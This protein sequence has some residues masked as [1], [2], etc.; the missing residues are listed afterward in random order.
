MRGRANEDPITPDSVLRLAQAV[1]QEFRKHPGSHGVVIGKDTRLS[2]YMIESALTSGFIS[3]G[4]NVF[5]VGPLPTPAIAMLTRSL[6]ADLGVMISAS[7][8]PA[9]DN[10]LKFFGPD[11]CKLDDSVQERIEKAYASGKKFSLA[12]PLGMGRARRIDDAQG[13]YIEFV[14]NSFPKGLR[15]EGLKIVI[16][17]AHGAAYKVAPTVFWE[18]GAEVIPINNKPDGANINH[19]CGVLYP[20]Q[21]SNHVKMHQADIGIA[22]DGDADRVLM[23]DENGKRIDG[24]F[25]LAAIA[26][27]WHQKKILRGQGVIATVMSNLGL[28]HYLQTLG[29][30][31]VRT[32]V[33]D[34]YVSEHMR[35]HGY[36]VGGEQSGHI[37]LGDSATTG[38]GLMAALQILALLI[39]EQKPASYLSS[40]FLPF[41]QV[42]KNVSGV[43]KEFLQDPDVIAVVEE[44]QKDLGENG[45][46]IVR[47]SGTENVIRIMAEGE[48]QDI[49]DSFVHQ[50]SEMLENYKSRVFLKSV[51]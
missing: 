8:N 35:L 34:R 18:L 38:D 46:L 20:A 49:L 14:K 45:R 25:L 23:I 3:M 10:G 40:F 36:N 39:E 28:E 15:L 42:L 13:R 32:H 16:D 21:L 43:Q 19:E 37:I 22:L 33:G 17:C 41:P 30:H 5:L 7:H 2:G 24:D 4:M 50:V 51:G 26:T 11:G 6:R 12:S 47:A 44:I 29:L 31:L 1:A 27:S 9:E 48:N